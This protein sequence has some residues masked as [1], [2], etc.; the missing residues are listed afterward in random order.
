MKNGLKIQLTR[1]Q[2]NFSDFKWGGKEKN[3]WR[4]ADRGFTLVEMIVTIAVLVILAALLVPSLVG[5]IDRSQGKS[6]AVEA[7]AVYLAAQTI[8]SDHYDGTVTPYSPIRLCVWGSGDENDESYLREIRKLSGVDVQM[9]KVDISGGS[10]PVTA[11]EIVA[12]AVRFIPKGK[13][14]GVT[15][16]LKDGAWNKVSDGYNWDTWTDDGDDNPTYDGD[17]EWPIGG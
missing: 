1:T 17:G 7:R 10:D 15:M 6:H 3:L 11:H 12:V 14:E 5:W 16:V 8:E 9:M 13:A 4:K 2:G